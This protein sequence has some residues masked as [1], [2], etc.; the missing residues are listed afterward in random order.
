MKQQKF[1]PKFS[2]LRFGVQGAS[3]EFIFNKL[4]HNYSV[5][6]IRKYTNRLVEETNFKN[7]FIKEKV[8][9]DV[10]TFRQ[11]LLLQGTIRDE[12]I[13]AANSLRFFHAEINIFLEFR[14]TISKQIL[15]EEYLMAL[16]T[17]EECVKKCGYSSWYIEIKIALLEL[18]RGLDE[19]KRFRK[20]LIDEKN[21]DPLIN[22]LAH[23]F[24]FRS[25]EKVSTHRFIKELE[26]VTAEHQF[27]KDYANFKFNFFNTEKFDDLSNVLYHESA[28]SIFDIYLTFVRVS[29]LILVNHNSEELGHL[30]DALKLLGE[31]I[32]D[33]NLVNIKYLIGEF[34][35]DG[36]IGSD[37]L[38]LVDKYTVGKYQELNSKEVRES[39]KVPLNIQVL[40]IARSIPIEEIK[41]NSGIDSKIAIMLL[42]INTPEQ[43]KDQINKLC[44]R[45]SSFDWVPTIIPFLKSKNLRGSQHLY[46]WQEQVGILSSFNSNPK[47][48]NL[49]NLEERANFLTFLDGIFKNSESVLILKL[50]EKELKSLEEF[51]SSG[52]DRLRGLRLYAK[53]F[54][55]KGKTEEA[56]A[57]IELTLKDTTLDIDPLSYNELRILQSLCHV[58]LRKFEDA[59]NICV[60]DILV[61]LRNYENYPLATFYI[62]MRSLKKLDPHLIIHKAIGYDLIIRNSQ[63]DLAIYKYTEV[64]RLLLLLNIRH[65]SQ[66]EVKELQIDKSL[67]I[68]FLYKICTLDCLDYQP[69]RYKD[70]SEAEN[71]RLNILKLLIQIDPISEKDYSEEVLELTRR[72][73]IRKRTSEIQSS[74]IFVDIESIKSTSEKKLKEDFE[75]YRALIA[76][77]NKFGIVDHEHLSKLLDTLK[78]KNSKSPLVFLELPKRESQ[79][80]FGRIVID[81]RDKF[82]SGEKYGLDCYISAGIRHGTLGGQLRRNLESNNVISKKDVNEVYKLDQVWAGKYNYNGA[83]YVMNLNDIMADFSSKVDALIKHATTQVLKISHRQKGEEYFDF[84]ISE[85]ESGELF[86]ELLLE[87][88]YDRFFNTVLDFLWKKTDMNLKKVRNYFET[89]FKDNIGIFLGELIGSLTALTLPPRELIASVNIARTATIDEIDK[90]SNWFKISSDSKKEDLSIATIVD[91]TKEIVLSYY[92]RSKLSF[93]E[94][95]DDGLVVKGRFVNDFHYL[96]YNVL[97]NI[98]KHN[99]TS[100]IK[101]V[102]D[103]SK[104]GEFLNITIKNDLGSEVDLD[105]LDK[106]VSTKIK[107]LEQAEIISKYVSSEGGSGF[108]K[109]KKILSVD[110]SNQKNSLK[111]EVDKINRKFKVQIDIIFMGVLCE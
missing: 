25:E 80:A 99:G 63:V 40:S 23:W 22:F 43:S 4:K 72:Q 79:R 92:P 82:I 3:P 105:V 57:L 61:N 27:I 11:A 67:L 100:D 16:E 45:F 103:I 94:K 111:I 24:S 48:A 31:G 14:N 106:K 83:E 76:F 29:Q 69:D 93:D 52:V 58:K 39:R 47:L 10:S 84:Y 32:H 91:L 50:I 96:F 104:S 89:E 90:I 97:E 13:W 41:K 95:I 60:M 51:L 62:W 9:K 35:A 56:E 34:P 5:A 30:Y 107:E 87:D 68:Y 49:M 88:N 71:E 26:S 33:F 2:K 37:A 98:G 66:L 12:L 36:Q 59:L 55:Q 101:I 42:N 75:R 109:V 110:L 46:D 108:F 1:D 53:Y 54:F 6:D 70:S 73:N 44:S 15:N 65:P 19:Q 28:S 64:T 74:K 38:R 102:V 18:A 17:L 81:I 21:K 7:F 85:S 77:E 8:F 86:K 20:Q 78:S